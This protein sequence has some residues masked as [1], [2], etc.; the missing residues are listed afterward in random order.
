M[1]QEPYHVTAVPL[2]AANV[3]LGTASVRNEFRYTPTLPGVD[4]QAWPG[5][6]ILVIEFW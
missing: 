4:G 1:E 3:R 5:H 2:T 6:R